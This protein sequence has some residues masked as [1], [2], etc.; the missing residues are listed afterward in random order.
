MQ[1]MDRPELYTPAINWLARAT[2][3][4]LPGH[5]LHRDSDYWFYERYY[6]PEAVG[7][8]AMEE[9]CGALNLVCVMEPLKI[10]RQILGIDDG[11]NAGGATQVSG[12]IRIIPRL[13]LG[14]TYLEARQ[15]PVL[16]SSGLARADIDVTATR[17]GEVRQVTIHADRPLDPVDVRM[18]TACQPEW[19]ALA[20]LC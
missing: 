1:L 9:G 7:K 10:A 2:C 12:R 14:W 16:T 15:V 19:R 11:Q 8:V 18:G 20:V 17:E 3:Q 4:L 5:D 13:P 6:T